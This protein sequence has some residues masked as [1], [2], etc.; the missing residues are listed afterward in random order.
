M[1]AAVAPNP[2]GHPF[3]RV[4]LIHS[5]NWPYKDTTRSQDGHDKEPFFQDGLDDGARVLGG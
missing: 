5:R 4:N 3:E 2:A 1:A